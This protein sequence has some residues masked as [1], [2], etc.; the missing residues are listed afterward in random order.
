M[1]SLLS[2]A[3]I[4]KASASL[5]LALDWRIWAII[6]SSPI[7]IKRAKTSAEKVEASEE[8]EVEV[9]AVFLQQFKLTF[10]G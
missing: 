2:S 5:V 1:Y 9:I 10:P 4:S 8:G 6:V 3:C 7:A